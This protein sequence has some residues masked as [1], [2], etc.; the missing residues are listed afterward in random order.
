M[1]S[2]GSCASAMELIRQ[3]SP[4]VGMKSLECCKDTSARSVG[5][6]SER[7]T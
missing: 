1:C 3:V 5:M 7:G 4:K 2:S 6:G